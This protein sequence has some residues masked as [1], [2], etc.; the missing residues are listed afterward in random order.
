MEDGV[1][2]S[3]PSSIFDS[4]V[5]GSSRFAGGVCLVGWWGVCNTPLRSL[6]RF[7]VLSLPLS[8][9]DLPSSIL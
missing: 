5:L 1:L 6:A 7:S 4:L 8:I 9:L 3:A 2:I